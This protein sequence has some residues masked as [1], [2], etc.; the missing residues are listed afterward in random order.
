VTSILKQSLISVGVLLQCSFSSLNVNVSTKQHWPALL[1][2]SRSKPTLA[3]RA[4]TP[5][6][7]DE[8]PLGGLPTSG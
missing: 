7:R 2:L 8:A 5:R 6:P 1:R 3:A 4:F